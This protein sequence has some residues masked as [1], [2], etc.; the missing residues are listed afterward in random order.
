MPPKGEINCS[1]FR[2]KEHHSSFTCV[3]WGYR[4]DFFS[5]EGLENITITVNDKFFREYDFTK[6][7]TK[8]RIL[9]CNIWNDAPS[10]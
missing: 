10:Q 9:L 2:N 6:P 3:D 4:T 1:I 8:Q 5:E 7:E